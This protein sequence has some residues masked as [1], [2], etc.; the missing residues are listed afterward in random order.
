MPRKFNRSPLALAVL[1]LLYEAP[2]HPYRMQRLIK[3]RGKDQVINVGQRASLYQT[4]NQLLRAGL[5]AVRE[6]AHQEGFPDRTVYELTDQGRHTALTWLREML[7]TPAQEFP[8]FPAAVSL[9]PLLTPE[10]GIHQLEI[11]EARLTSQS[12]LIDKDIQSYAVGLPR[13]FL[14][15]AEYMRIMLDAE[16]KWV[17]SVIADLRAGQLTWNQEWLR[18]SV[19]PE[20]EE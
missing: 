20:T 14:L 16:L 3:D 9:L 15:E 17:R 4:I 10:D 2:M 13:L 19:P 12:A 11:R 1:A 6:T 18:Q 7:S 5:I 8:E